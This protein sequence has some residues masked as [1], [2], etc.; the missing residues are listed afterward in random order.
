MAMNTTGAA[1][2][3]SSVPDN[4]HKY[5][6]AKKASQDRSED[7]TTKQLNQQEAGLNGASNT[8]VQ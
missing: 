7:Q 2:D 1:G 5:S 6:R 4:Q 3:V 8:N